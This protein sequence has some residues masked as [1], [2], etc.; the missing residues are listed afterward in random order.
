MITEPG[1]VLR[2]LAVSSELPTF[3]DP[4][5]PRAPATV[6]DALA[7]ISEY[8]DPAAFTDLPQ[9]P[10]DLP[11]RPLIN[12]HKYR[13][14]ASIIQKVMSFKELANS[15]PYEGEA[16]AYKKCLKIQCLPPQKIAELSLR[17]Q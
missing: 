9:V 3:L 5:S 2:D 15:Y 12:V 1:L 16:Y 10:S 11:I 7:T 4:S 14:I 17:C 8:A 6:S 13:T